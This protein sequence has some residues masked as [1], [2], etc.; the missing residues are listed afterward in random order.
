LNSGNILSNISFFDLSGDEHKT[1]EVKLRK[2]TS[3]NTV[4]GKIDLK[5]IKNLFIKD[6]K[7]GERIADAGVVIVWIEPET[8]PTTHII[9]DLVPFKHELDSWGGCFLFLSNENLDGKP[10]K[11]E[12]IKGLPVNSFF[13]VDNNMEILK[14]YHF[15]NCSSNTNLPYVIMADKNCNILFTSS[16]YRIGTGEQILKHIIR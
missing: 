15:Q 11:Y 7:V 8:E 5:D 1:I 12:Q 14:N 10:A 9:N 16:G 13:G 6:Q 4:S 3:E 2:E